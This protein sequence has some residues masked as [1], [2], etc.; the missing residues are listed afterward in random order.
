[1]HE[2]S[3]NIKWMD[4]NARYSTDMGWAWR[5]IQKLEKL[6][7]QIDISYGAHFQCS[8]KV[9]RPDEGCDGKVYAYS[10]RYKAPV[11]ICQAALEAVKT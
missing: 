4:G 11:A 3:M 1:M 5:V 10:E 6:G 7:F 2:V 8:V 9:Y